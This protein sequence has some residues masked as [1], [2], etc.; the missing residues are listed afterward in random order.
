M[1]RRVEVVLT[2][3]PLKRRLTQLLQGATS[4]K[5]AFFIITVVK[6]SN[7]T[8]SSSHF[9]PVFIR[10]LLILFFHLHPP[11]PLLCPW[12]SLVSVAP[13]NDYSPAVTSS[14]PF[15]WLLVSSSSI[16]RRESVQ[17]YYQ[18]FRPLVLLDSVYHVI[19]PGY[20]WVRT[21]PR[22]LQFR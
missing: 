1:W 18:H 8:K 7:L 16:I 14:V 11:L 5:T 4:Q 15:L 22:G 20:Y 9:R 2:D 17:V 10:S 3:V 13:C 12:G 6:T 21:F 19:Y